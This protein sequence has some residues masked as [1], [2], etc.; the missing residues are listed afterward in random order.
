M[1]EYTEDGDGTSV[2]E[3]FYDIDDILESVSM[4]TSYM[5]VTIKT[6]EGLPLVDDYAVTQ[7]EED[8]IT[9]YIS[10]TAREM[11]G[12]EFSKLSKHPI[13]IALPTIKFRAD[14][15][16][17]ADGRESKADEDIAAYLTMGAVQKWCELKALAPQAQ[18][19]AAK[20]A[21]AGASL[22]KSLF[23]FRL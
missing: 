1:Y 8:I 2:C 7:D 19:Y 15:T 23:E 17:E 18:L 16:E 13:E 3:F 22:H 11:A 21:E 5:A 14:A 12:R 9:K 6:Q 10:D 4:E 20:K